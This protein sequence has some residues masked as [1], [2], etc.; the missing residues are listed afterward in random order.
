M[1]KIMR[2]NAMLKQFASLLACLIFPIMVS[3]A[4]FSFIDTHGRTHA[5][6]SYQGKWVLVNLWAT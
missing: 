3:A 5:L 6:E 1:C 2:A 4:P